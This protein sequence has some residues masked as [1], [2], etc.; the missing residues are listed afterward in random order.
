MGIWNN[1]FSDIISCVNTHG[2]FP[3][4]SKGNRTSYD[5]K[6]KRTKIFLVHWRFCDEKLKYF[7]RTY[8]NICFE[9]LGY[10]RLTVIPFENIY[11]KGTIVFLKSV[12]SIFISRC[13]CRP[14]KPNIM[15]IAIKVCLLNHNC[16]YSQSLLTL[17]SNKLSLLWGCF[18]FPFSFNN[19]AFPNKNFWV[20]WNIY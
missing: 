10:L 17:S 4:P 13:S 7:R 15:W 16:L 20:A 11:K 19:L 6:I 3:K 18:L 12:I 2:I 8:R 9:H 1:R 5:G 14:C